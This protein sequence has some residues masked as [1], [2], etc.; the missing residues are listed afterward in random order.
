MENVENSEA[1][2]KCLKC[3]KCFNRK[4]NLQRHLRVHQPKVQNYVCTICS[5]SFANM[6]NMKAH[7]EN[8]HNGLRIEATKMALVPNKG[9]YFY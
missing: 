8:I 9:L 5:T 1:I 4:G 7:L 6:G 3:D 2:Y